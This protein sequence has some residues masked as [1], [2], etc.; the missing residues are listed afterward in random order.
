[1]DRLEK[2][3]GGELEYLDVKYDALERINN[4]KYSYECLA[5]IIG[6]QTGL[7]ASDLL[8]LK[9]ENIIYNES[10]NRYECISDIKKTGAK[11]HRTLI[12]FNTILYF[13][14]FILIPNRYIFTNP[15]TGKLFTHNWLDNRTKLRYGLP[16]DTLRTM[17]Y[18]F[19]LEDCELLDVHKYLGHKRIFPKD[20]YLDR[21]K[22][23]ESGEYY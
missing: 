20:D 18:E 4:K 14:T 8:N 12:S 21:I 1:M 10:K 11:N 3:F 17:T 19:L 5:I 7:C 6:L 13:S 2:T 15:K 16:F 23:H 22:S 9:T